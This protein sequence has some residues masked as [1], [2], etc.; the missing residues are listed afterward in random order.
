MSYG[1][2]DSRGRSRAAADRRTADSG[3]L[4]LAVL[5]STGSIGRSTLQVVR[6]HPDKLRVVTLAARGS[7]PDLLAAQVAEMRPELV[8]VVDESAAR[9]L[10][11]KLPP[12]TQLAVGNAGVLAAAVHPRVDRLV[13]AMVGAA[14]L[15]PAEAALAAGIDVA[16]ANKEALVVA[17]RLLTTLAARTGASLLPIDSEHVALHQA[18]RAGRGDEVRQLVLTASGGP[19][20]TRDRSTFGTIRPEEALRHPTWAMGAKI[21][22]DSATLMNKGLELIEASHLFGVA[23]ERIDVVV[24]P[25]SIVHSLVEYQDGS[26]L[27]QL[28]VNDMI[29]PIQYALAYPARWA[30]TFPRL[31]IQELGRLDFESVDHAAFPALALARQS[32]DAGDSAPAV[33]NGANEEAVNA[34]LAGRISF[35]AI[36]DTVA[37][38]LAL[39]R[40]EPLPDLAAALA[41]DDWSRRQAANAIARIAERVQL[42]AGSPPPAGTAKAVG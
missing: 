14:G 6:A 16:L 23:A 29:F 3:P 11:G 1:E 33:L 26:W 4:G 7:D 41:W 13:A 18:L 17:G 20:R 25:Q 37:E 28:A 42:A 30:N 38:V 35:P 19:F 36:V 22:I 5:G 40:A 12:G 10:A 32:L 34:F 15:V 31:S 2:L 24:H 21:T 27:A 39:H 9:Q 8:A